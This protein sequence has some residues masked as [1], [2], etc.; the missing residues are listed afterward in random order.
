MVL[1]STGPSAE[2]QGSCLGVFDYYKQ[3]N[4][5]PAYRQRHSVANT[6]PQYLYKSKRGD[7]CVGEELG[8]STLGLLNKTK[9]WLEEKS[10]LSQIALFA[11]QNKH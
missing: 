10:H 1:T 4:K 5:C 7:W 8:G 9:K 6:K 11:S 2:Y 3:W